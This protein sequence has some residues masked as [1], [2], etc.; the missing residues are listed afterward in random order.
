MKIRKVMDK[1]VGETKY[2]KYLITL[3]KNIVEKS[4]LMGRDLK[5]ELETNKIVI[6]K[7]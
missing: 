2:Y 6:E 3:P 5:V 4:K 7:F 1:K